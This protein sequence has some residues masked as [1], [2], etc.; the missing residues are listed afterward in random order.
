MCVIHWKVLATGL[1]GYG[2]A[3]KCDVAIA[4]IKHLESLTYITYWIEEEIT[5]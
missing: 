2:E 4:W 3:I 5:P 1:T